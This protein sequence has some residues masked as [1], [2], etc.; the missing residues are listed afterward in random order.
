[1]KDPKF[2]VGYTSTEVDVALTNGELDARANAAISVLRRNP[3]WLDKKIMNFHAIM[4]IPK[5]VKHPRLTHLPEIEAFA[6]TEREKKV[7]TVWRAFRGVGSPYILPP[8]TPKDKLRFSKK[9]CAR[10]IEIQSSQSTSENLSTTILRPW[11][12]QS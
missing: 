1:M 5:G 8:G 6:K 9:R 7:L 12:R 10:P 3:E 11:E 4:E 2:I